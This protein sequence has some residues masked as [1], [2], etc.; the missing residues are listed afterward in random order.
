MT[1]EC[2]VIGDQGGI[3]VWAGDFFVNC[4]NN[5]RAM[6]L[7]HSPA[8]VGEFTD[9]ICNNGRIVGRIIG[10]ESGSYTSQLNVTLRH[11]ILL[12]EALSVPMTMAQ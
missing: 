5:K 12:G 4:S 11:L 10:V 2:T 1:Y 7:R 8:Q 6:E 3:T 9:R